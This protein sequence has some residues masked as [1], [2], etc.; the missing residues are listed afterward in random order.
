MPAGLIGPSP[1]LMAPRRD[2]AFGAVPDEVP[3]AGQAQGLIDNIIIGRVL[4]LHQGP[5]HL[6]LFRPAGDV[7]FFTRQGVE[8]CIVHG[9]RQAARRRDEV[10]YLFRLHMHIPQEF[11]QGDGIFQ[12]TA[13]M[14]GHEIRDEVLFLPQFPVGFIEP[15]LELQEGMDV[16]LAHEVRHVLDDVFR[17]HF[18]LAADVVLT[19]FFDESL[20]VVGQ[21]VV[22][23]QA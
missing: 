9:R 1:C 22:I 16:G 15:V 12:G 23:A 17:R 3:S 20:V 2:E 5:L 8:A 21:D 18:Q 19:E 4:I 6:F 10:L 13:G 14:A 11:G 7:D